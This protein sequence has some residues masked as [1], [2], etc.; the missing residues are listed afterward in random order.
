MV[1]PRA[2]VATAALPTRVALQATA[3][4]TPVV[5]A[6]QALAE[7]IQEER[8]DPKGMEALRGR[9]EIAKL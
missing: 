1:A 6:H 5:A 7:I 9:E 8:L 3:E 4:V 2:A